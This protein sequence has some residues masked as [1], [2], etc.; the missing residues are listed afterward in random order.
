MQTIL[1]SGEFG[2][3][4]LSSSV[5]NPDLQVAIKAMDKI[6]LK[7]DVE[8]IAHEVAAIS[9]LDHPNIINFYETYNDY[10]YVYLVM[11]YCPG[12]PLSRHF[13]EG[14]VNS[15]KEVRKVMFQVVSAISHCH[16]MGIIH[17]DI[18][19]DNIMITNKDKQVKLI[20]FGL[21]R[22]GLNDEDQQICGT[23]YYM[24]PEMI[25]RA[26]YSAKI[27]VW[28]MGVML[29]FLVTGQMPFTGHTQKELFAKICFG[30]VDYEI[31]ALGFVSKQCVDLM[32]K[33]L[34]HNP[35]KRITALQV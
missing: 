30:K 13:S 22:N 20:D 4:F 15:E 6:K 5:H 27:D 26:G 1:G 33:M 8:L 2:K 25:T 34:V 32:K 23:P 19:P 12:K 21:A 11:E 35:K 7:V 17:R 31:D 10:R 28:S 9:K 3:V 16:A 24:A 29:Y 18:K 14:K